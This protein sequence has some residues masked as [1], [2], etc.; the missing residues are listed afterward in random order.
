[1]SSVEYLGPADCIGC[2][3]HV[4]VFRVRGREVIRERSMTWSPIHLCENPELRERIELPFLELMAFTCWRCGDRDVA[5]SS[6]GRLVVFPGTVEAESWAESWVGP[7]ELH[8]CEV[9]KSDELAPR[10][11]AGRRR[12]G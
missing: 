4:N 6:W 9:A 11:H 1:M 12:A 8:I 3:V 5:P 2:A 10:R 7:F